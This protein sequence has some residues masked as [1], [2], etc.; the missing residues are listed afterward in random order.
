MGAF[1]LV[2]VQKILGSWYRKQMWNVQM[3][4][5]KR[6]HEFEGLRIL[7]HKKKKVTW[8][9]KSQKRLWKKTGEVLLQV[10]QI[11]RHLQ[12]RPARPPY[13]GRRVQTAL[14]TH[15][16]RWCYQEL[17]QKLPRAI[18]DTLIHVLMLWNQ[19]MQHPSPY[20]W[21]RLITRQP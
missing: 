21:S 14:L 10:L 18:S 11:H 20:H 1:T 6:R 5:E 19:Q 16:G 15:H 9:A 8:P 2:C 3:L 4:E 13:S 17:C 12:P 7:D